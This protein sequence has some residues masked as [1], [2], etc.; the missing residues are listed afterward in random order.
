KYP[1]REEQLKHARTLYNENPEFAKGCRDLYNRSKPA[2]GSGSSSS[3]IQPIPADVI[4]N[5][6]LLY[7][8][9]LSYE[10]KAASPF[11]KF[12]SHKT[13]GFDLGA[14]RPSFAKDSKSS[15]TMNEMLYGKPKLLN[16]EKR[17]QLAKDL[18]AAGIKASVE[19]FLKN[20]TAY[21]PP[22]P[23]WFSMAK[24]SWN[25]ED[26][27]DIRAWQQ[28]NRKK[29]PLATAF[30]EGWHEGYE[31]VNRPMGVKH[32]VLNSL[33]EKIYSVDDT[34]TGFRGV[35]NWGERKAYGVA[36][37]A[38]NT[39][40]P[41]S[42]D[43]VGMSILSMMTGG[44]GAKPHPYAGT[45]V[46]YK[47]SIPKASYKSSSGISKS[48][49]SKA[50]SSSSASQGLGHN[51][52]SK[53]G[54]GAKA[55]SASKNPYSFGSKYSFKPSSMNKTGYPKSG[56]QPKEF[57]NLPAWEKFKKTRSTGARELSSSDFL[58]AEDLADKIYDQIRLSKTDISSIAKNTGFSESRVKRI[59]DHIFNN[60]HELNSGI[61]R[62][63]SDP[64][65]VEAWKRL[66]TG[67]H[68]KKDIDLLKHE[69]FES[70]F[71][72]IFKTNYTRAHN[73]A[74]KA[75]HRS[76]LEGL[77]NKELQELYYGFIHRFK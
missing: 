32:G 62:F 49:I 57:K 56:A 23:S 48:G 13:P 28:E 44:L 50:T 36:H 45:Y 46:P 15:E 9:V 5:C 58:K 64:L 21:L 40:V 43:D 76:P 70:K 38:V 35:L 77:S 24:R 61:D 52:F 12:A 25:G 60:K 65:I 75:G 2:S 29:V 4:L 7:G 27:P 68:G 71:E 11:H 10:K 22:K 73:A 54:T 72:G 51:P 47:S 59:K 74:N 14:S 8:S 41:G 6:A 34:A 63:G 16:L 66:E 39:F 37:A 18:K 17:Q 26:S 1:T 3:P 30:F 42:F 53:F 67:S 69:L 20:P 19:D 31:R 55:S 33:N